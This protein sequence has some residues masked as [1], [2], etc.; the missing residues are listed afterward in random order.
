MIETLLSETFPVSRVRGRSGDI[1]K[2]FHS[3]LVKANYMAIP[4]IKEEWKYNSTNYSKKKNQKYS[5][6][7]INDYHNITVIIVLSLFLLCKHN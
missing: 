3:L 6:K 4:E 1:I 5:V 7:S 2:D